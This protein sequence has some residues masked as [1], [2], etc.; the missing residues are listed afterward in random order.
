MK[1]ADKIKRIA[2]EFLIWAESKEKLMTNEEMIEG[3]ATLYELPVE[4]VALIWSVT[5]FGDCIGSQQSISGSVRCFIE[6]KMV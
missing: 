1:D 5:D 3:I 4:Q 6:E 2:D